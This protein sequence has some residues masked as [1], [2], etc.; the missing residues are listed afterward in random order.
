MSKIA[1]LKKKAA[2]LEK[3][4]P[5]KAVAVYVELIAEMERNPE[6]MDVALLNRVGD[7]M[8]KQNNVSGAVEY[9]EKAVD[10]YVEGGFLNN[11]I[12]LCNKIL[13]SSP[14]RSTV[15]YKLG[16]I[17]AHKGFKADA[18]Q[19]FLEYADRMRKAGQM[20]EAFRALGEFADLCP[21]QTDIRLMLADQL[22]KA[23]KKEEAI[24]Q[25]Q[26]LHE[27]LDA[28]GNANEAAATANRIHALDPNVEPRTGGSVKSSGGSDDLI[29]IDLGDSPK[30]QAARRSI[31]K[32]RSTRGIPALTPEESAAMG[33]GAKAPEAPPAPPPKRATMEIRK[34]APP[35]PPPPPE[36]EP[37]PI[38]EPI[39][40]LEEPVET[41]EPVEITPEPVIDDIPVSASLDPDNSG[42]LLGFETTSLADDVSPPADYASGLEL[43]PTS[44]LDAPEADLPI[45]SPEPVLDVVE[46]ETAELDTGDTMLDIIMP[47]DDEELPPA[48]PSGINMPVIQ[49]SVEFDAPLELE[50]PAPEIPLAPD[51]L[52]DLA[53]LS[54]NNNV[55]SP[56]SVDVLQAVVDGDPEDWGSRRELAEALLDAGNRDDGVRELETAML[57]F[58][59]SGDLA[60]AMSVADEIVRIDPSSVKHHQ[61]RVEYA[62]R[63]NDRAQLVESYLSLADALFRT[64]QVDKSRTIYQRVLELSPDDLRAQAALSTM[65]EPTPEPVAPERKSPA[66]KKPVAPVRPA[67]MTSAKPT[68]LDNDAFVNLGDWLRDDEIP[69]DTRMVVAE[70]EPTGNEE[71]DFQDMLRKFKQGVA[72]NVEAE[73]YQS[74]Y[75]LGVAYK[76]MGLIDEAISEFQKALRGPDNRV[77]TYEAIGQCFI[78]KGQNQMAATILARA[79]SE[80]D[81]DDD[82][83]VGVLYL[84]GRAY[85]ALGKGEDALIYYQRVFVVD[86][87]FHDVGERMN[88]LENATR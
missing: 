58:E 25:L 76:E 37:E 52:E 8:V 47:S 66:A 21:D 17:S 9:Y 1:S 62:Y 57:G 86:I 69:K 50:E 46:D 18:K 53:R 39:M 78:E 80:K 20:D 85:E 7:L 64:G 19:N 4:S 77:R 15:Y 67:P 48:R 10:Y 72:E 12:A 5:D 2:D 63:T 3:K 45:I 83:L 74:H 42:S 61:K 71:A 14:G 26:I 88:A 43:E 87:Q 11:A 33:T 60:T 13:R 28:E 31:A 34:Q 55:V 68:P 56:K 84:L 23:G 82:Q 24:E 44:L 36:P 16:K 54:S 81:M 49:E 29:F 22:A 79:L 59:R 30:A 65:P 70:E 6:D 41:I 51:D 35:P 73:D 75:D 40:E 32:Q 27:Q 38:V